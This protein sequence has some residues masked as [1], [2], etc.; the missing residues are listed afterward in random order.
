MTHP[1]PPY[2]SSINVGEIRTRRGRIDRDSESFNGAQKALYEFLRSRTY[3]FHGSTEGVYNTLRRNSA[4]TTEGIIIH[5]CGDYTPD[6]D[7]VAKSLIFNLYSFTTEVD[8]LEAEL[9]RTAKLGTNEERTK[10]SL[11]SKKKRK[12][13]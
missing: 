11:E 10:Q 4:L 3:M 5:V 6:R 8:S 13:R 7:S 1:Q 2:K 9:R 12:P